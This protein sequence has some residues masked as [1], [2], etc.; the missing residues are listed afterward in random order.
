MRSGGEKFTTANSCFIELALW[1]RKCYSFQSTWVHARFL[2]GSC[3]SIFSFLCSV[4]LI[5]VC[6]FTLF[7]L[8]MYVSLRFTISYYPFA[9]FKLFVK[10]ILIFNWCFSHTHLFIILFHTIASY[11]T[12]KA[13][14]LKAYI[15]ES[16]AIYT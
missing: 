6:P 4:L 1:I 12:K 2:M 14:I 10:T 9:I 3:C 13:L 11:Q 5:V 7:L 15:F 16:Y 8:E